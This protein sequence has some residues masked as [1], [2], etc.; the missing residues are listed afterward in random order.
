MILGQWILETSTTAMSGIDFPYI[1]SS[2]SVS[3]NFTLCLVLI[4][5]NKAQAC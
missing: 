1:V 4:T 2:G 5:L 3:L